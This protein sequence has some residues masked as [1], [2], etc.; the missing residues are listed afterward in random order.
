MTAANPDFLKYVDEHQDDYI[1][2]LSDAVA[3][4]S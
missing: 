4:P 2:R 3:I 1:K